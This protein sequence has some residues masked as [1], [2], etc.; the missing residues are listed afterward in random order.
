MIFPEFFVSFVAPVSTGASRGHGRMQYPPAHGDRGDMKNQT[1][2]RTIGRHGGRVIANENE[3]TRKQRYNFSHSVVWRSRVASWRVKSALLSVAAIVVLTGC[4]H[5]TFKFKLQL[6]AANVFKWRV[7]LIFPLFL[8]D[9]EVPATHCLPRCTL[10]VRARFSFL[11]YGT[12][13]LTRGEN[14]VGQT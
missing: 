14:C 1:I 5:E 8:C 12:V 3:D 11:L 4:I 7:L 2:L 13:K 10:Y 9:G 6:T